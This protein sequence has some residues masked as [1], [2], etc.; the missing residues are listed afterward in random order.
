MI[1][2]GIALVLLIDASGSISADNYRLQRDSTADALTSAP[3]I[4]ASRDGLAISAIMFGSSQHTVMPWRVLRGADDARQA[5][6]ALRQVERPEAGTTDMASALRAGYAELRAIPCEAER[7]IIDIS[8]DGRHS[9]SDV[10]VRAAVAE[11]AGCGVEVNALALVTPMEPD[12]ADWFRANVTGPAGG[13]TMEATAET[14]ARAIRAKL[15]MET[16]AR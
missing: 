13:F 9:G 2:C 11:V 16:A 10:H 6:D 5:R 7:R 1:A 3:V 15:A 14:F 4:S 8:G 12:I